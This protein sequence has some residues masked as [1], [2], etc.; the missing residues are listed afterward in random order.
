MS[1]LER[2]QM[3]E[4]RPISINEYFLRQQQGYQNAGIV[5]ESSDNP[6]SVP[7]MY[8]SGLSIT[9][10]LF[11]GRVIYGAYGASKWLKPFNEMAISRQEQQL[12][13]QVKTG[14]YASLLLKEQVHVLTQSVQRAKRT[15]HEVSRQVH[16]GCFTQV[17]AAISRSRG[18]QS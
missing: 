7:N 18:G 12:V 6:F 8:M 2:M 9:Q 17:S 13:D 15:L 5:F 16:S 11:D 1:K 10:K 3:Q 4:Q 14:W